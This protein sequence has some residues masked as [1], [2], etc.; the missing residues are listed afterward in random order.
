MSIMWVFFIIFAIMSVVHIAVIILKKETLRR[1]TK[2]LIIPPLLA[3]YIAGSQNAIFFP[4]PALI[5]GWI[6]DILLVKTKDRD[7]FKLGL[8]AFLLGHLCYILSYMQCLS[9]FGSDASF[10]LANFSYTSFSLASFSFTALAIFVPLAII[11][12]IMIFR[13][14]KPAR[15]IAAL[16]ILYITVIEAMTFWGLQ[17]FVAYPGLAGASVF[18]G[19]LSFMFS[20]TILSYKKFRKAKFLGPGSVMFFYTL[21]QAGIILG[22]LSLSL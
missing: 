13:I 11:M 5:L 10:S 7:H 15:K 2:I 17:V 12:G 18:F 4:I 8:L 14:I 20:D 9:F 19:C 1:I 22:I 16:V 3:A 6:G 21:A